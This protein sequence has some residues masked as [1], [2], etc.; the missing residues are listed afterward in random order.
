MCG[1]VGQVGRWDDRE[2]DWLHDAVASLSHRGPDDRGTWVDPD[3]AVLLGH[4]RLAVLDLSPGGHQPF[5]SGDGRWVVV[6]NGEVYN[7]R[8][9]RSELRDLGV[10]FRSTSDTEV[11]VRAVERWGP[12][13]AL[14]RVNGMFAVGLWDRR[15][16]RLGLAR[17]RIGEKPLFVQRRGRAVR[18]ASELKALRA[19]GAPAPD[20][21]R[22]ALARYLRLG[23]VPAPGSIHVGITK[24]RPGTIEW[25]GGGRGSDDADRVI[26]TFWALPGLGHGDATPDDDE[27]EGLIDD[28]VALRMEADVPVGA[29]L[30][31]GID[32]SLVTATMVARGAPV[33]TFTIGFDDPRFDESTHAARIAG[34]LGTEHTELVVSADEARAV[35]P[36]LPV[37]FDEPFADQ[38]AIPTMLVAELARRHVTVALSGDGGDELFGGYTRYRRLVNGAPLAAVPAPLARAVSGAANHLGRR[39]PRLAGPARTLERVGSGLEHGG[40]RGLYQSL[41][42]L[43]DDPAEVV[44]SGGDGTAPFG[45]PVRWPVRRDLVRTAM[46]ADL[47]TYLPDDILVKVDRTTMAVGLEARVPLLDHRIVE[48]SRRHARPRVRAESDMKAPLRRLLGRHVPAE[49]FER[50]KMG[51]GAPVG[52]WLRGPLRDWADDLLTPDALAVDGLLCP[53]P[54]RRRWSQ[55]QDGL[56]DWSFPL[57]AVLCFQA[58]RRE[59][60]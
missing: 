31:G 43:W 11:L 7:H 23:Y 24:V 42:S 26:E 45:D 55:H 27:L 10:E 4:R 38:S 46:G 16:R 59:W 15:D 53:D 32:S 13:G 34:H 6:F 33:R 47:L 39:L 22:A 18:F 44:G 52:Q 2:V 56:I 9:L 36:R 58:W 3:A 50:P 21:D 54:I 40:T 14:R 41:V 57:W 29:F 35:V 12:A 19:G 8:A 1:I 51:F 30:S 48:W 49:L 17:D 20:V 25:F 60:T 5:V 28:S 37:L